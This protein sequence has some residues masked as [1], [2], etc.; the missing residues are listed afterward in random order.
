MTPRQRT[1]INES[2]RAALAA[3]IAIAGSWGYIEIKGPDHIV[4]RAS[5]EARRDA[6][7]RQDFA[8]LSS[9]IEQLEGKQE[10]TMQMMVT[11]V[12]VGPKLVRDNQDKMLMQLAEMRRQQEM[13]FIEEQQANKSLS[14]QHRPSARPW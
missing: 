9:R 4:S 13:H 8:A 10:A 2:A 12:E 3:V 7:I 11:F 14:H 1:A 6:F 5:P